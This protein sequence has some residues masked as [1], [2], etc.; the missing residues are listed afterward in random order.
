MISIS[1]D[2]HVVISNTMGVTSGA[3]A[4]NPSNASEFTP[5]FFVR[6]FLCSVL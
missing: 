3:G 5:V 2:I 1:D 4:A 6:D